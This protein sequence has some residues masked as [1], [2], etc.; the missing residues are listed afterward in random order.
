MAWH[1]R[2]LAADPDTGYRQW[3]WSNPDTEEVALQNEWNVE[4]MAEV[5]KGHFNATDERAPFGNKR[6]FHHIGFIPYAVLE[7]ERRLH[8][9]TLRDK[10]FWRHWFNQRENR[11]WRTRP[12]RV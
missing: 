8:G 12:G 6:T 11:C 3:Y 9:R 4:P 7:E 10:E 1:K 2:L 5:A